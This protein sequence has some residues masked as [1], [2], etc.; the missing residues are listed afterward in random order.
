MSRSSIDA[1][2]AAYAALETRD[3]GRV[4]PNWVPVLSEVPLFA[5]LSRRHL[6]R[7]ASLARLKRFAAGTAIVRTGEPGNAFYVILQG[8]ARVVPP[9]GREVKLRVGDFF[10]EMA[11]LDGAPRAADVA[12]TEE[13]L[14]MT[15]GR[16]AFTK[17]L[18]SEPPLAHAVLQTLAQRLR[19]AQR[20][21]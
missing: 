19:A 18:R 17:L 7:V 8:S 15:I 14:A 16:S 9:N 12:A 3:P 1:E 5:G 21:P 11:L 6:R 2:I 10:G 20:S 13:L 4:G